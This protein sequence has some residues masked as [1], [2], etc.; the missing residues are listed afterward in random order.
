MQASLGQRQ[1]ALSTL[2]Q[3]LD[4]RVA[5]LGRVHADVAST[6][7]NIGIELVGLGR[8]EEALESYRQ[9]IDIRK[10]VCDCDDCDCRCRCRY[11]CGC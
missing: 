11:G 3:C 6:M 10:Q 7:F 9:C 4:I 8:K 5:V 2:Q 1:E